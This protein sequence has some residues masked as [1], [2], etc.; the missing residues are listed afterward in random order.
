[1]PDGTE[2]DPGKK[3]AARTEIEFDRLYPKPEP[4]AYRPNYMARVPGGDAGAA[5]EEYDTAARAWAASM[6]L[7]P[8]VG[9][10]VIGEALKIGQALGQ[11]SNTD[12]ALYIREQR[13]L[14]ER[15][16]GGP[17][18]A[19]ARIATAGKLLARAPQSFTDG[20]RASGALDSAEIVN[21]LAGEAERIA[22]RG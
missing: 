2:A 11:V 6:D 5:L 21:L 17:E 18:V 4:S 19:T 8:E 14:F 7:C 10:H 3:S 16:S 22:S 15:I 13:A 9:S 12:R 1:M 20:L